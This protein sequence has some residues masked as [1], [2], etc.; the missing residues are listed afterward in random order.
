MGLR[1]LSCPTESCETI[2]NIIYNLLQFWNVIESIATL[3]GDLSVFGA[4]LVT[5]KSFGRRE[6]QSHVCVNVGSSPHE[7]LCTS[8]L[9]LQRRSVI[10]SGSGV[11]NG[12]QHKKVNMTAYKCLLTIAAKSSSWMSTMSQSD[13][14]CILYV[15]IRR[16]YAEKTR[17]K[18]CRAYLSDI[19]L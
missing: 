7:T 6:S 19:V 8:I 10:M 11:S 2:S 17:H 9:D 13:A 12:C 15:E 4:R 16:I 5:D 1:C 14:R 18:A 3:I